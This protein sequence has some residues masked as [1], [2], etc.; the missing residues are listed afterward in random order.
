[1]QLPTEYSDKH[2]VDRGLSR[3]E[4]QLQYNPK[5][6]HYSTPQELDKHNARFQNQKGIFCKHYRNFKADDVLF[7]LHEQ[8]PDQKK[9][10]KVLLI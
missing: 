4:T 10:L 6:V 1:M 9:H 2:S 3:A 7:H 5:R 8:A